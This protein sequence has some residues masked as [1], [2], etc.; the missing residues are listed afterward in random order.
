MRGA[1][2]GQGDEGDLLATGALDVAAADHSPRIGEEHHLE[3]HPRRVGTGAGAVVLVAGIEAGEIQFVIDE[4]VQGMF[5]GARLQLPFEID[6]KKARAGVDGLVAGHGVGSKRDAPMTL[7][8]PFGS[9]HDAGM[10]RVFL[11]RRSAPPVRS[12][13]H[14]L[15]MHYIVVTLRT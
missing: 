9:R 6:G 2:A 10:K 13:S 14:S 3:Q 1:V 11:Q 5:E 7:D 15:S 8:I 4:V 12:W